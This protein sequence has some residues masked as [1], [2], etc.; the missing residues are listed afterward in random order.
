MNPKG[1]QIPT[2]WRRW[3]QFCR[4][5]QECRPTD[6]LKRNKVQEMQLGDSLLRIPDALPCFFVWNMGF[7]QFPS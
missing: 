4:A 5:R 1:T 3:L 7:I 2:V 6:N